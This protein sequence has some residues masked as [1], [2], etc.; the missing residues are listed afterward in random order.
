MDDS[1][2]RLRDLWGRAVDGD[3]LAYREFLTALSG[4][5]RPYVRRQ[6]SR[7]GRDDGEAD[8]IVQEA[9]LAIHGKRHTYD[10]SV[11]VMAWAHAVARYK[12]ID[13]LRTT[14]H[15]SRVLPLDDIENVLAGDVS[16]LETVLTI[17]GVLAALPEKMRRSIE[18]IKIG[19][20]SAREAAAATGMSES[21]IKVNVHRAIKAMARA[22]A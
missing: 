4:K 17:R 13:F 21:A 15:S 2:P 1:E 16:H 12:M 14:G 20:L 11:P 19:G 9:L 3:D 6:L 5:L 10:R 8:D 7:L 22:I 18:L